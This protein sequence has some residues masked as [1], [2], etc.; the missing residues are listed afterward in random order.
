MQQFINHI[1]AFVFGKF[2]QTKGGVF[3]PIHG[4]YF[5]FFYVNKGSCKIIF[6]KK[7]LIIKAGHCGFFVAKKSIKYIYPKDVK[8]I[9]TW[10]EGYFGQIGLNNI[11]TIQK[12]PK[13]IP[14]TTNQKTLLSIGLSLK[15]DSN[16]NLNEYR[17]SIGHACLRSHYYD[18]NKHI[19][20]NNY[21]KFL[22][23][24]KSHIDG[25]YSDEN[26]RVSKLSELAS[27]T[28]QHLISSFKKHIG[29]T[30]SRYIW[31]KRGSYARKLLLET[32]LSQQEIAFKCGYKSIPHFCRKIKL[33]FE[34]T[35]NEIRRS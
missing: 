9:C 1:N 10:C 35:P 4:P 5:V 29:I 18:L 22:Y 17:N 33:Q 34:K 8:T 19:P 20:H 6:D 24:V 21:P 25:N 2:E 28:E 30:P 32:K 7:E 26:L 31:E 11:K 16:P 13:M 15:N 12:N 14:I 3:G 23:V 27:V